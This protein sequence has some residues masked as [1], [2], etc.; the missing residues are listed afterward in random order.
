MTVMERKNSYL[1][2]VEEK[3]MLSIQ[4][5]FSCHSLH[6]LKKITIK[7]RLKE[8][9]QRRIMLFVEKREKFTSR[10]HKLWYPGTEISVSTQYKIYSHLIN[11]KS[12][13]HGYLIEKYCY[14]L[15]TTMC[16]LE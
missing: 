12:V 4:E 7:A 13:C 14:N 9:D 2:E 15:S 8:K 5:D 10:D 16:Y 1:E 6:L 3:R 11:I